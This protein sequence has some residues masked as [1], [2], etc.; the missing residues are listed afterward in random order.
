MKKN[1][2]LQNSVND[3]ALAKENRKKILDFLYRERGKADVWV[4]LRDICKN[5]NMSKEGLQKEV[6]YLCQKGFVAFPGNAT[7]Y[8]EVFSHM[9]ITELGID[10]VEDPE[11]YNKLFSININ[12]NSFGDITGSNLNINSSDVI[13]SIDNNGID[14]DVLLKIKELEEA[15]KNKDKSKI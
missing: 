7:E 10:L 13:Q 15:I 2:K 11:A 8:D 6:R 5:L 4:L 9:H 1:N 14:E 3:I 12:A